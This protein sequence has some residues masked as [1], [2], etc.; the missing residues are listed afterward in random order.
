[1]FISACKGGRLP[2]KCCF[3]LKWLQQVMFCSPVHLCVLGR[4]RGWSLWWH[5]SAPSA[6]PGNLWMCTVRNMFLVQLFSHNS[7]YLW[8]CTVIQEGSK[9]LHV[10]ETWA[11]NE[12]FMWWN[13]KQQEPEKRSQVLMRRWRGW[14]TQV[15]L[16]DFMYFHIYR[17]SP[18]LVSRNHFKSLLK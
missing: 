12:Y 4:T 9:G 2:L 18:T 11:K 5:K 8:G 15:W 1:M 7:R 17:R 6:R 10:G 14:A 16:H 3:S 13:I